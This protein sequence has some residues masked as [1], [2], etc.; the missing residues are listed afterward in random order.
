MLCS[1]WAHSGLV[2]ADILICAAILRFFVILRDFL[3][4]R[5][6]VIAKGRANT[7]CAGGAAEPV[8]CASI[9][10]A[11]ENPTYGFTQC[12]RGLQV[13]STPNNDR[14]PA[15]CLC[16]YAPAC[17]TTIG[18]QPN[19]SGHPDA[20]DE[21]QPDHAIRH[22]RYN[23]GDARPAGRA[24]RPKR[25]KHNRAQGT[26]LARVFHGA[27]YCTRFS[28]RDLPGAIFPPSFL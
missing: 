11:L 9:S 26:R 7:A 6:V 20:D 15:A 24:R 3:V 14:K 4:L 5:V 8:K 16:G 23:L 17:L 1:F 25:S 18:R 2:L 21:C 13:W 19:R 22:R 12:F 27:G 10:P 28:Q